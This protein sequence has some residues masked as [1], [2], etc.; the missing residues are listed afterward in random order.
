L[1][2]LSQCFHGE[3]GIRINKYVIKYLLCN[4]LSLA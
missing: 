4:A 3:K 2:I 1:W